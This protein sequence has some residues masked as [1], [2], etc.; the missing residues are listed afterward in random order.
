MDWQPSEQ[1]RNVLAFP[2]AEIDEVPAY[3]YVKTMG[4][5]NLRP[6]RLNN[7]GTTWLYPTF[8]KTSLFTTHLMTDFDKS[9][10]IRH[11]FNAGMQFDIQIVAFSYLKTTWSFGYARRFEQGFGG[12]DQIMLSLKLLGD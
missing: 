9:D 3:N 6:I 7:V 2:G 12:K 4:E 1:Y 10:K 11:L 8:I 5:L